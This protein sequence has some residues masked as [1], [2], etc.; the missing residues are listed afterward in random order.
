M[1]FGILCMTYTGM[2]Y[3]GDGDR[4]ACEAIIASIE[5]RWMNFDQEPFIA[6]VLLNPLL[7]TSPFSP[8][9][10][11]SLVNIHHLL[12]SLFLRFFPEEN[13]PWLFDSISE[14]IEGMGAFSSMEDIIHEAKKVPQVSAEPQPCI[15]Y[16]HQTGKYVR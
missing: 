9:S 11:F 14:Y 16:S 13:P 4:K 5:K 1:T 6:A 3:S 7:K 10:T 8:H 2:I 12:Q 15:S